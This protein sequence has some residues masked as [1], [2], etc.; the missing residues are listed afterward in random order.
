[1][2]DALLKDL[3]RDL[4]NLPARFGTDAQCRTYLVEAR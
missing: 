4:P 2:A 3:P 1:M